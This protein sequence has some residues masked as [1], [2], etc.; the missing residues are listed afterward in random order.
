M[1]FLKWREIM[2]IKEYIYRK[3]E[4]KLMPFMMVYLTIQELIKDGYIPRAAFESGRSNY[5]DISQSKS[6]R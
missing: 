1:V 2:D 4:F 6:E 5:V 3:P